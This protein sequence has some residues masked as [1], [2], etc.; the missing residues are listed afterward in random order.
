MQNLREFFSGLIMT[1]GTMKK[2]DYLFGRELEFDEGRQFSNYFAENL[3][4]SP[5]NPETVAEFRS[6]RRNQM[7]S[8]TRAYAQHIDFRSNN[9]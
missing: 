2:I 5:R 6:R 4:F 9:N 7:H 3:L 1:D 8:Q